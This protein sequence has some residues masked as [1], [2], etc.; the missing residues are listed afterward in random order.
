M[1]RHDAHTEYIAGCDG[2]EGGSARSSAIQ[3]VR[4]LA[5]FAEEPVAA[6]VQ[7]QNVQARVDPGRLAHHLEVIGADAH[8]LAVG[9]FLGEVGR[10]R[11]AAG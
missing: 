1:C 3:R 6:A 8:N 2:S 5:H 11:A 9:E 7:G 10:D 4:V